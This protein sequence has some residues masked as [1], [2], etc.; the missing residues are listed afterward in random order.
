MIALTLAAAGHFPYGVK[1]AGAFIVANFNMAI[2]MRHEVF[3]CLLYL[4]VNTLFAK[5]RPSFMS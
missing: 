5:V 2:L 1:Y 3:G 4:L